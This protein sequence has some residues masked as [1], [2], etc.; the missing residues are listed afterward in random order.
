MRA[1]GLSIAPMPASMRYMMKTKFCIH[2]GAEKPLSPSWRKG[3]C[4]ECSREH[5]KRR[6]RRRRL[7]IALGDVP[8]PYKPT[9]TPVPTSRMPGP[10]RVEVLRH[11]VA[12]NEKLFHPDDVV[13]KADISENY[14]VN[15]FSGA[16]THYKLFRHTVRRRCRT[17]QES[18][19]KPR[20]LSPLRDKLATEWE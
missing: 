14:D 12:N 1:R 7:R 2:C 3:R 6:Q 20:R 16:E 5:N 9:S 8:P 15:P 4:P 17:S 19:L 11:R 13:C 18:T 10:D